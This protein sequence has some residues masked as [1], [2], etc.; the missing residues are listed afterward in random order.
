M[1]ACGAY[2]TL[3]LLRCR[4]DEYH[5]A[6]YM[7][8]AALR[9]LRAFAAVPRAG[10]RLSLA[11]AVVF[12]I[13]DYDSSRRALTSHSIFYFASSAFL[14]LCHAE[15]QPISASRDLLA[16]AMRLQ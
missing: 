4:D 9:T 15:G 10:L 14:M 1:P 16:D 11:L 12:E 8:I 13:Y 7:I 6:Y 3:A 5:F 2:R